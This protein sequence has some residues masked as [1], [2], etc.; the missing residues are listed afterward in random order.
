MVR[1]L[2]ALIAGLLTFWIVATLIQLA[3]GFIFGM[4]NPDILGNAEKMTAYVAQMPVGAFIALLLSYVLSSFASG[5]VARTISR[6]DSLIIPI[7]IGVLETIPWAYTITQIP[8]P[9]WVVVLGFICY[10]PFTLL[11]H[12][13][14]SR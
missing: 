7:V 14:A 8:H 13:V 5:Y 1:K 4:P 10:I 3:S 2:L 11:G 9:T 6:S 12:R